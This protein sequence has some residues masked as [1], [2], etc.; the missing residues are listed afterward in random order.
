M[1]V[2]AS[3][4][5]S[6]ACDTQAHDFVVELCAAMDWRDLANV[7]CRAHSHHRNDLVGGQCESEELARREGKW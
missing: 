7:T 5:R 2:S 6:P 4:W 1:F 3:V